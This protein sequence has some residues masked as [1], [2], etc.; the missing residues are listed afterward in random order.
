MSSP[1]PA[2]PR[3]TRLTRLATHVSGT[4][5][6]SANVS[7]TELSVTGVTLDSRR[8][9]PGDLYAALPGANAHGAQFAEQAMA[10]GATAVLTDPEGI[11]VM[12]GAGLT[13]PVIVVDD[14]RAVLG[15]LSAIV[16]GTD[17]MA[18]RLIGITGTNGKTTTAYLIASA[19][20]AL[21]RRTGLIGTVET[22]I[23]TERIK[24]ARTTPESPDLHGILGLMSEE[25]LDDCVMEV[26]SHALALHRVDG[27]L[28]DLALF[29]NLSQD[30]LDFHRTMA[31]YFD[32]KAALFTPERARA[33]LVCIDDEWGRRLAER[34]TIP[35]TT[36]AS[37]PAAGADWTV[38]A[39][40]GDAR[41]TLTG[42]LDGRLTTL[43]LASAL[44]GDFNRVNT[45][46]AA[47]TLLLDGHG[48]D[49]VA[50]AVLTPPYVPGRMEPVT[51][52]VPVDGAPTAV[53]DYAHTPDAVAALVRALRPETPGRLVVLVGAGGDRDREKRPRMGAAA[54][55]GADVVVVTD[56]NPRSE[57]P[58]DIR[59]AVADG[60]RAAGTDAT[61]IDV[62]GR[63]EAIAV[64]VRA[65]VEGGPGST[66]ALVGKG[67]ETGQEIAGTVH[68]FDDREELR[69]AL[70]AA[71][72]TSSPNRMAPD[73]TPTPEV[74]A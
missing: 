43:D 16:Y 6:S 37:D 41:F 22:R 47:V 31:E 28:Y 3:P 64:A 62:E 1:R 9:Q 15:G 51:A 11:R 14:P 67:H 25:G 29:T 5:A 20:E 73:R 19:L 10:A 56:D 12:A 38:Q 61:I 68:P 23:G 46:M 33:G 39:G 65:A 36:L 60:A 4:L 57:V 27:V 45:A 48:P 17:E 40:H 70:D 18:P 42:V 53:V 54:A 74:D 59:S 7:P 72:G 66:V 52:T 8:V 32:A 63:R 69:A 50:A 44:P 71:L 30:H 35:V 13:P 49:A 58:A 21:G 26:S 24:S 2:T 55:D 34:A